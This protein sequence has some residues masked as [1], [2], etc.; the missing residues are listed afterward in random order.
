[1][2]D[3]NKKGNT[4]MKIGM[5]T[6]SHGRLLRRPEVYFSCEQALAACA[7]G[8]FEV[9]NLDFIEYSKPGQP[10]RE[11]N[12]EDWCRQQ[13]EIADRLGLLVTYAH[14]P[15]YDWKLDQPDGD[16]LYE[17]L[18]R[19]SIRGAGIMGSKQIVFHPG[20]LNDG[21]WY[22]QK[23]SLERNVSASTMRA[24]SARGYSIISM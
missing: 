23:L 9:I 10:M 16:P 4:G 18:I 1:M 19:R 2:R 3:E 12:W 17:E 22:N 8:G 13:R 15:F 14:A 24:L 20:S 6:S 7:Q 11:D 5:S 21:T